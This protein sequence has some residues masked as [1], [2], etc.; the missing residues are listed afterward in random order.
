MCAHGAVVRVIQGTTSTAARV[1]GMDAS[2]D[3]ALLRTVT[4][5][6]GQVFDFAAATP[7]VTDRLAV[8]G[9]P[10]A[11]P[12]T[13]TMGTVNGL[14]RTAVIE[15]V[16]L[17]SLIEHDAA[18]PVGAAAARSS[19]RAARSSACTTRVLRTGRAGTSPSRGCSRTSASAP[20]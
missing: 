9:V 3:V 2:A 10:D 18:A 5:L 13:V 8:L 12:L 4:P 14:D 7:E 6:D 17:H 20:G 11:A 16:V 1:I 15:G 19:T